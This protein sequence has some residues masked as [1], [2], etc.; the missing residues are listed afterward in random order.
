M[1]NEVNITHTLALHPHTVEVTETPVF[2]W[3][4]A[5]DCVYKNPSLKDGVLYDEEYM[6]KGFYSTTM[7]QV[8]TYILKDAEELNKFMEN[9]IIILY[10]VKLYD[11]QVVL[12][13]AD[14][15]DKLYGTFIEEKL[16]KLG[17]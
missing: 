12:R 14:M 11:N 6:T 9:H 2:T 5:N 8:E 1:W 15:T 7:Y 16:T 13:C 17:F 4:N 10:L 3:D